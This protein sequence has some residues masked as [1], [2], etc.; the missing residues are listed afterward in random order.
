MSILQAVVGLVCHPSQPVVYTSCL[1]G[2]VRA[3]DIR[4]GSTQLVIDHAVIGCIMDAELM[5]A[6][7][8]LNLF[9]QIWILQ[10]MMDDGLQADVCKQVEVTTMEFRQLL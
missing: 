4:T 2:C 7:V 8:T 9:N 10:L 1:D 6:E 3:W 5:D